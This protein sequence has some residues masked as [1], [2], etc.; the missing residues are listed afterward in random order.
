ML[1]MSFDKNLDPDV[2]HWLTWLKL[3][4][5]EKQ[6][7]IGGLNEVLAEWQKLLIRYYVFMY[8]LGRGRLVI[9]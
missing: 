5:P 7:G 8:V 1:E 3:R 2:D 4:K 9:L 6:V